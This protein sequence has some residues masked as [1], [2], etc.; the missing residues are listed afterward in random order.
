MPL[1]PQKWL[2]PFFCKEMMKISSSIESFPTHD[3]GGYLELLLT[4]WVTPK[5]V[6]G[7]NQTD[8]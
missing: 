4:A 5:K 2:E 1:D 7:T 3:P 6:M 8:V